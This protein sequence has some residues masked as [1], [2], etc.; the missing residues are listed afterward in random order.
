[1]FK[2]SNQFGR[3][4]KTSMSPIHRANMSKESSFCSYLLNPNSAHRVIEL[5]KYGYKDPD[6]DKENIR[7][8][9]QIEKKISEESKNQANSKNSK[10]LIETGKDIKVHLKINLVV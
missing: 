8:N 2:Q 10:I 4:D 6:N 1:M 9:R 5:N 7:N 3:G